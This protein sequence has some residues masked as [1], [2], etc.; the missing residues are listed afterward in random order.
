MPDKQ[1]TN[2]Q[3]LHSFKIVMQMK[4]PSS[5]TNQ[6][7]YHYVEKFL[8]EFNG[9][10]KRATTIDI[11][12]Y[13][14]KNCKSRSSMAQCRS[15]LKALYTHV[16]K[17][18]DKVGFIPY[19][20]QEKRRKDIPTHEQMMKAIENQTN[21]KHKLLLATMYATGMR[22]KEVL[23]LKWIDIQRT[24]TKHPLSIK[25]S[26]KG[27][28]DRILP[29]SQFVYD[30]LITYCKEHKLKCDTNKNHYIFG[31]DRPYS[32]KSV[33]LVVERAGK[34]VGIKLTPH[35]IRYCFSE[36]LC[37]RGIGMLDIQNAMGHVNLNT[38]AMYAQSKNL[39]LDIPV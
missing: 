18:P 5:D 23:S 26:G 24:N 30:L 14:V 38:T 11:M 17:Q 10:P 19:P 27:A 16:F 36:T 22:C 8:S 34:S 20:K 29:L 4:S 25:V 1:Y 9:N 31:N 6:N 13:V 2:S 12:E 33:A 39:H 32:A 15:A 7:Y 35:L 28:K 3:H 37:Y 21:I